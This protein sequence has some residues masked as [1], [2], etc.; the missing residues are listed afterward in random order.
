MYS[1]SQTESNVNKI[2]TLA[3]LRLAQIQLNL[4][5]SYLFRWYINYNDVRTKHHFQFIVFA[6]ALRLLGANRYN[7]L[8]LVYS[9]WKYGIKYFMNS[10]SWDTLLPINR[11]VIEGC[12]RHT[13]QDGYCLRYSYPRIFWSE[14]SKYLTEMEVEFK[15]I[16]FRILFDM[17]N[18]AYG[19]VAGKRKIVML[20][21]KLNT[22]PLMFK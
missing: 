2:N 7:V 16:V 1:A 14:R 12:I 17:I 11:H 3:E 20:M 13:N 21:P 8:S 15:D 4:M 19:T 10:S 5:D 6:W 22:R 18:Y 9:I